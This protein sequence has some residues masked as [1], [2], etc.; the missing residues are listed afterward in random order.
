MMFDDDRAK[1]AFTAG[2]EIAAQHALARM[3]KTYRDLLVHEG[4]T[5]EEA[6]D[7]ARD[8]Q[9]AL[10]DVQLARSEDNQ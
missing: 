1:E 9:G 3:V 8:Y 5:H 4:F 7:L 10:F 2:E 6:F